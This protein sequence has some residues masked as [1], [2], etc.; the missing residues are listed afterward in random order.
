MICLLPFA[1]LVYCAWKESEITAKYKAFNVYGKFK[2]YMFTNFICVAIIGMIFCIYSVLSKLESDYAILG[3]FFIVLGVAVSSFIYRSVKNKCPDGA[4]KDK[5]M[6]SMIISVFG[7]GL[8]SIFFFLSIFAKA[9][10][11]KKYV[12]EDGNIIYVHIDDKVYDESGNYVGKKT[13][14][15]T[16]LREKNK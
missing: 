2:A 6:I 11:P 4:L 16:Y 3:I 9:I 14:S 7:G 13:D 12:D 15:N 5:L 10:E 1:A 8:K